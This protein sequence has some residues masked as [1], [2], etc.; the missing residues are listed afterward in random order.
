MNERYKPTIHSRPVE[1]PDSVW[2]AAPRISRLFCTPLPADLADLLDVAVAIYAADRRS[3]R[4]YR[5]PNTGRRS[6]ALELSVREPNRWSEPATIEHLRD[7]LYWLS[8]DDWT[9][10]FRKR[11]GERSTAESQA[12]LFAVPPESPVSVSLFS[13]GLDSLAGLARAVIEE[14]EAT[15]VLVSGYT[16][17]RLLSQ[18]RRQVQLIRPAL[19]RRTAG[20]GSRVWYMAVGF[21]VNQPDQRAE[22]KSQRTR[23]L[24]YEALGVT[25]AI[26]AGADTLRVCENG[27]GALNLPLNATQLG[28]DNYRGVHPRSL[29]F[30]EAF[31]P[32]V[33]DRPVRIENPFLFQ[34]KADMCRALPQAGFLDAIAA[35]VSCDRFPLRL[36]NQ[37]TQCGYCTSCILRRQAL[38]ASGLGDLD[39]GSAYWQD[40]VGGYEKLNRDR[41]HGIIVMR[42]QVLQFRQALAQDNPWLGLTQSF[43]EI[44]RFAEDYANQ[45][46]D[47]PEHVERRLLSLLRTYV[48]EWSCFAPLPGQ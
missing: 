34:T 28:V 30:L 41:R 17:T 43:P 2:L 42:D 9:F 8:E 24:V 38:H 46:R 14:P 26:L 16:N 21:G 19:D 6:I 45:S 12:S 37:P 15:H 18:Q 47:D 3:R 48:N 7:F 31:L 4:N 5:G 20:A 39:P 22:E 35:T 23:A 11:S 10:C 27:I 1:A 32:K 40:P 33:L 36:Q 25:A 44:A 29:L 13:G